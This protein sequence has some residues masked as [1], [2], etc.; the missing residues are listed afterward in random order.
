MS[1]TVSQLGS[2]AISPPHY[3]PP[4]THNPQGPRPGHLAGLFYVR[5]MSDKKEW[6]SASLSARRNAYH[7]GEQGII[8]FTLTPSKP[9]LLCIW[10]LLIWWYLKQ[11]NNF[12]TC[13]SLKINL[14]LFWHRQ[15]LQTLKAVKLDS[16]YVFILT[17]SDRRKQ[18]VWPSEA[19]IKDRFSW[20]R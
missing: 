1:A 6:P 11:A 20:Q 12:C 10:G 4:L 17:L 5:G 3:Y 15:L 18:S 13:F 7:T 9:W 2:I 19:G 8:F 16:R 14:L